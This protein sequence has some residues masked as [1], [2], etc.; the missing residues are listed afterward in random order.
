[1]VYFIFH[2]IPARLVKM[3]VYDVER[4][5][6]RL[7]KAT[8]GKFKMHCCIVKTKNCAQKVMKA[9]SGGAR[10]TSVQGRQVIKEEDEE[11]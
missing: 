9:K 3:H 11:R 7:G 6:G 4:K 1:M 10:I 5:G 2:A 8:A